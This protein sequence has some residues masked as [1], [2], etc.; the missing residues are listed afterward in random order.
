M[1]PKELKHIIEIGYYPRKTTAFH[2]YKSPSK[3]LGLTGNR[4]LGHCCLNGSW[5]V[6]QR[7]RKWLLAH[8]QQTPWHLT[9]LPVWKGSESGRR[10]PQLTVSSCTDGEEE[11]ERGDKGWFNLSFITYLTWGDGPSALDDQKWHY[12]GYVILSETGQEHNR[13]HRHFL[14]HTTHTI[15]WSNANVWLKIFLGWVKS[16]MKCKLQ[17]CCKK[18]ED[19]SHAVLKCLN[20]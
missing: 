11:G 16:P 4:I 20:Y 3:G 13:T 9:K 6:G 19:H 5:S 12:T 15:I 1:G 8:Y 10:G 18:K 14:R 7:P 2:V 17:I